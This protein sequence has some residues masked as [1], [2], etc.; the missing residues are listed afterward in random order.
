MSHGPRGPLN[1]SA[2][3]A[4]HNQEEKDVETEIEVSC[5]RV[6]F[7]L[8]TNDDVT[9]D[10][11]DEEHVADLIRDGYNQGEL[12][13]FRGDNEYRGWWKIVLN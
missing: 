4:A 8:D 9:P 13:T 2:V 1:A 7:W 3:K 6:N 11:G 10:E 5:H 12:C